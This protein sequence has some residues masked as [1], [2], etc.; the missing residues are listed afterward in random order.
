MN[1]RSGCPFLSSSAQTHQNGSHDRRL[2]ATTTFAG[3][4][5]TTPFFSP[6]WLI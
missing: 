4:N 3:F 6:M 1:Q 2:I 5:S